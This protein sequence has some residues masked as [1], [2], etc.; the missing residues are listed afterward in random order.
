MEEIIV[1]G[2]S[3]RGVIPEST[4]LEIY[5]AI[6]IRNTGALTVE[7]FISTLSQ[8]NNTLSELGGGSSSRE[9]NNNLNNS[10]DLRGLGVGSTLVLLNGR[11]MAPSSQG[12]SADVS[13]IPIGSVERVEVLT[14][15]ASAIYG[16]DA[17]GGV[18]NFV[19][20]DQQDGAETVLTVG[21]ADGGNE[22][23]RI[24][25]S[26]G[27]SWKD[28]TAL[29]ALSHFD[30]NELDASDRDFAQAA[31]PFT[32]I[33]EDTRNSAFATISQL[34]PGD[35]RISADLLYSTRKPRSVQTQSQFG[36]DDLVERV[37]GLKQTVLNVAIDRPIGRK[38]NGGLLATYADAS[39]NA[40]G[41]LD[42]PTVGVG[43]F[44]TGED[45]NS[46]DITAKIDGELTRFR[47]GSWLFAL[48]AGYTEDEYKTFRDF[49]A[50]NGSARSASALGRDTKYAFAEL[51][52]PIV[53]PDQNINGIR[54]LELSLA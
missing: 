21:G 8:N 43:P 42:G 32:L 26:F 33:P 50:A 46:V 37:I 22:Q 29:V 45:T 2:T 17:I 27:I 9:P 15:G 10:V 24:D 36:A 31:A 14:D 13:L 30:R 19:L 49:S 48:G 40:D 38:L 16:A 20:K 44:L 4:P 28:G 5:D 35:F 41:F 39:A 52:A 25:Q 3:I 1:T 7:G 53:S 51:Q 23:V 34:L 11:R 18:I 6:E 47:S 54:R 12:R